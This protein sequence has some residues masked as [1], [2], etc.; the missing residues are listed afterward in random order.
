MP[1]MIG[2]VAAPSPRDAQ[3]DT[4]FLLANERTLLAWVR[5]ALALVAAGVG[6]HQFG[7]RVAGNS[8]IAIFLLL[9]G[10]ASAVTGAVRFRS[11]DRAIRAGVV[12]PQG[13]TPIVLAGAVSVI[14]SVVLVAV[15]V[16]L[17][18]R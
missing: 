15:V 12:P 13:R 11:A 16:D 8:S 7:T 6:V 2:G 17:L 3:T 5:T 9:S 14:A 1:A 18:D 4:R 10:I